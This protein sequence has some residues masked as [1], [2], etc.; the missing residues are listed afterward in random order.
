MAARGLP[1]MCQVL[2]K[3]PRQIV[4]ASDHPALR[5]R[6]D[7]PQHWC[8]TSCRSDRDGGFDTRVV[9]VPEYL[10]VIEGVGE[11]V[12]RAAKFQLRELVRLTGQLFA[13]LVDAVGVDVAVATGPDEVTDAQTHLLEIGRA[14]C[15]ETEVA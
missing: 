6:P 7:H 9:L 1:K 14:S 13:H 10:D 15:R 12:W 8:D 2:R 4:V 5:L 11:K 3:A